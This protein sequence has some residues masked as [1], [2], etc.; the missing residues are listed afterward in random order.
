MYRL[1]SP[2]TGP[3][4][5]TMFVGKDKQ[6]AV[7]FAFDIYPRFGDKRHNVCL[8]GLDANRQYK[9]SEINMMPNASS[10]LNG[11][12]RI[13]SGDYLMTVGLDIFTGNKLNSRVIEITAM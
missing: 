2:Y 12:D 1:V 7:V 9:V 3:H 8:E 10:S 4:A 11:N 13:Y 6:K 5:S